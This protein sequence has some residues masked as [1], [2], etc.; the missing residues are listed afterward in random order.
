MARLLQ[1]LKMFA[2]VIGLAIVGGGALVGY[3]VWDEGP[4]TSV[5]AADAAMERLKDTE[6]S[7]AGMKYEALKKILGEPERVAPRRELSDALWVRWYRGAVTGYLAGE[8]MFTLSI[9]DASLSGESPF[10]GKTVFRGSLHGL[11]I[12]DPVPT[13]ERGKELEKGQY[14][15]VSWTNDGARITSVTA[16][17]HGYFTAPQSR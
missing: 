1:L 7:Q 12:G 14:V 13:V 15:S 10:W 17:S 9:R 3:T 16:R 4:Y 6:L 11:R 8:E 5:A 2:V